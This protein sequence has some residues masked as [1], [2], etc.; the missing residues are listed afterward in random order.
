MRHFRPHIAAMDEYSIAQLPA[1]RLVVFVASTTGQAC[2][3][4]H[5]SDTGRAFLRGWADDT[6]SVAQR[7]WHHQ[8]MLCL[9]LRRARFRTA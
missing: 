7:D 2:H 8:A 4:L 1:S 3:T 9:F 6:A 5:S